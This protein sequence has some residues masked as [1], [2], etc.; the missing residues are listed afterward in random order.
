MLRV[1][2]EVQ[3]R[4][5]VE[6]GPA[7]KCQLSH[8]RKRPRPVWGQ[9]INLNR[10]RADQ[11]A[12]LFDG[13]GPLYADVIVDRW[14]RFTGK[15]AVLAATKKRFLR[16]LPRRASRCAEPE[17][18]AWRRDTSTSSAFRLE[19]GTVSAAL[20]M[21]Q[22]CASLHPGLSNVPP[23]VLFLVDSSFP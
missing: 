4:G 21:T 9:R 18:E 17:I 1:A 13:A 8:R 15:Q 11:P 7:A 5:M 10:R 12:I 6:E 2:A 3:A 14:Q 16:R 23:S 20:S 22:G 19:N